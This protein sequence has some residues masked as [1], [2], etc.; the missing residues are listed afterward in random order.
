MLAHPVSS[1]GEFGSNG[2]PVTVT[3]LTPGVRLS[4]V[5]GSVDFPLVKIRRLRVDSPFIHVKLINF[6]RVPMVEIASGIG[7]SCLVGV[8][9]VVA[10][11]SINVVGRV[12]NCRSGLEVGTR[13]LNVIE[14]HVKIYVIIGVVQ[15]LRRLLEPK[16]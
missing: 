9:V 14:W 11:H 7:K 6:D 3:A 5:L 12:T 4:S 1:G 8:S 10:P 2:M 13:T 16:I 15:L